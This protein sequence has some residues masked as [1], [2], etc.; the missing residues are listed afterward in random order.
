[1]EI[2]TFSW[3]VRLNQ[4]HG[5]IGIFFKFNFFL[6]SLILLEKN[7]F[8]LKSTSGICLHVTWSKTQ[9]YNGLRS[10][11]LVGWIWLNQGKKTNLRMFSEYSYVYKTFLRYQNEQLCRNQW[12]STVS[13]TYQTQNRMLFDLLS[14][15]WNG[16]LK[17]LKHLSF[18][19]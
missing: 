8:G 15:F 6:A 17:L 19:Y 1:M 7:C 13:L 10:I 14:V 4:F 2:V 5:D 9:Q 16:L 11:L 3:M 12:F 18:S